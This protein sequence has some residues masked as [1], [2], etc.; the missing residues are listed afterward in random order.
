[1]PLFAR[2]FQDLIAASIAD[3]GTG[4][5]ITRL[6]AGGIARAL[7]ES[8]NK[9]IA[10]TYDVFDLNMAR[11]FVS[12]ADGKY[13]DM[14]GALL[15]VTRE[16]SQAASADQDIQLQKFYVDAGTFGDINS[17]NDILLT[18]GT[19]LSTGPSGTGT[20]YRVTT[21][22]T[23]PSG[24]NIAWVSIEAIST[25]E[26]SN[27]G[28]DS[29]IYHDFVD[30]TD[31]GAESL[32]TSN[33]YAIA[34]GKDLESDA[35]YRFRIVN[36]V[37]SAEAAN[38][39]ALRLAA[40]SADGV[41]D[42]IMIPRYRG[43]ATFGI[44]VKSVMPTV[45]ESLLDA[46]RAKVASVTAFGEIA[47][48]RGPYE[49]GVAMKITVHYSSRLPEEE[50]ATIENDLETLITSNINGLDIGETFL[51][52]RLAA[53]LFNVSDKITNLGEPGIPYDELYIYR[54]SELEDNKVRETLLGDYVPADDE[55]VIIEPSLSS[56]VVFARS[57]T[58]R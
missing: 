44:I 55:R 36:Q 13:L 56:P 15:G 24:A 11:A 43:I 30:Y 23:L 49:T 2:S 37:L 17:G 42:V 48:I 46:V 12:S 14:I 26:S 41:A 10:E 20:L 40:L 52:E 32:K 3:I 27:T 50:L 1:M 19:V 39:T 38:E 6:T 7:L 58:R 45:S 28:S 31:F 25:G 34:T 57:Y 29:L 9:R 54:Q 21:S 47:F 8:I 18:T 4:T 35:N 16:P 33:V 53:Q 51:T 22:T 5:V